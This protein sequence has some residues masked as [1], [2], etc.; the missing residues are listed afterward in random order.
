MNIFLF[1]WEICTFCKLS[2]VIIHH[3]K[4]KKTNLW[5]LMIE[6]INRC[7]VNDYF[8]LSAQCEPKNS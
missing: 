7:K 5:P 3:T 8:D 1:A 6:K 4:P 2:Q